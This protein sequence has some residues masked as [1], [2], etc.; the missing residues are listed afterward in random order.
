[1]EI[2]YMEKEIRIRTATTSD[3]LALLE[4]YKPYV[5][6]TLVTFECEVPSLKEFTQR[7]SAV[8]SRYPYIVAE[9]D[10]V[11]VG[12]SYAHAFRERAAYNWSVETSIYVAREK[13]HAGTGRML[14]A[15]LEKRLAAQNITTAIACVTF[16]NPD[17]IHFHESIG[18]KTVGHIEKCAYKM[19]QWCDILYMEKQLIDT[20]EMP[21]DIL[22]PTK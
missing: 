21:K 8:S 12:Y 7:I 18:Y 16:P 22:P 13:R 19:G 4:I 9:E 11:I 6:D 1:M 17:S 3:A 20:D 15:E 14:Y 5:T 10:G 2:F